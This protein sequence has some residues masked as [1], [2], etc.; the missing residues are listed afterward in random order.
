MIIQ[1]KSKPF[2]SFDMSGC[3][4]CRELVVDYSISSPLN[5]G[6]VITIVKEKITDSAIKVISKKSVSK[7][8]FKSLNIEGPW[9]DVVNYFFRCTNCRQKFEL[10][11]ETFRGS[12]GHWTAIE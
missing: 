11:A 3:E 5:L 4:K 7:T 6:R 1:S 2:E 8:P 10:F 12:G 9:E